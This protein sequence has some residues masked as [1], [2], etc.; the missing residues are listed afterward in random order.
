MSFSVA[1]HSI[2]Y[3]NSFDIYLSF[4]LHLVLNGLD[5]VTLIVHLFVFS[6]SFQL[7]RSKEKDQIKAY[8]KRG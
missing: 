3:N 2:T 8:F 7:V 6:E 5:F 4:D 1:I